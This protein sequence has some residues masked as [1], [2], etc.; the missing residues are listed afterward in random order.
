MHLTGGSFEIATARFPAGGVQAKV[1][2]LSQKARADDGAVEE[3]ASN[4]TGRFEMSDGTIRFSRIT[5][6]IPGARVDLAGT[7]AVKP[8]TLDFDGTVRM[9]A[10]LSQL[11]Q[12]P[13]AFLLKLVEPIFRRNN[14][15]VIPISL[16]GTVD[17]PKFGLDVG[18]A[19]SAK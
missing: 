13:K 2:E 16:T 17:Q 11:T 12:G 3:V 19:F 6:T 4:L 10:R 8:E 15:T 9:D 5:F 14:V 7:Y 1:N 18:R